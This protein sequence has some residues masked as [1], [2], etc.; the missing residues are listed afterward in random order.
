MLD[1]LDHVVVAVRNLEA[2]SRDTEALLGRPASWR[3]EHPGAGTA[4]VLFRLENTV[5]ELLAPAGEGPVGAVI[6]AQL[7]SQGEGMVALAFATPDAAACAEAWR[8]AG[9]E[10]RG[11]EDG[12]GRDTESGAIRRWA[13]VYAD[14]DAA[15]GVVLF[16]I[17]RRSPPDVVALV[18]PRVP[19]DT[20]P[21]RLDHAVVFSGDLEASRTLYADQLG[22]RLALDRSFE[23][24]G[25]RILFFRVGGCTVEVVGSLDPKPGAEAPDRYG[26]L[27]WRV[28]DPDAARARLVENG[29]DVTEVRAG[30][31]PGTRVCTV[32]DR[33]CGVPTLLIG[34]DGRVPEAGS[35]P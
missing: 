22:L 18:S 24:R 13:N 34:P 3:G 4:N 21:Q 23:A 33:T 1:G 12:L 19:A 31:K 16:A 29:F 2:A 32:R 11:P 30:A 6:G 17:E 25:I 14:R 26:G 28:G 7:E 27:A 35:Q 10:H 20:A 8:A 9:L 15:R 5:L